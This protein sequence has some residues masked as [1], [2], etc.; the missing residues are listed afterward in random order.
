M[1]IVLSGA[2]TTSAVAQLTRRGEDVVL[3]GMLLVISCR[4]SGQR[5]L[6]RVDSLRP[7]NDFFREGDVWSSVRRLGELE[8]SLLE[9]VA[10][11]YTLAELTLI[12]VLGEKGLGSV[13]RPPAP[14]ARVLMLD[15]AKEA[16]E[17]F[18]AEPGTPGIVW[19]GTLAGYENAP[20]PL[21]VEN[22]TMHMGVFGETGSGKSY[23]VGYL[24]ELLSR[25]PV[26]D[27]E[28]AIPILVIDA[29]GD[30][31]DYH[32]H[33]VEHGELGAF[34]GVMRLVF[35]ISR[36]ANE[37]LTHVLTIGLDEFTAR[38][39]AEFIVGYKYGGL[40]F[41]ELQ[42]SALERTL[43]EVVEETGY[44]YTELLTSRIDLVYAKLNELSTG[45]GAPV[46]HQTAK[47]VRT[48]LEKFENDLVEQYKVVDRKPMLSSSFVD[49]I[50]KEPWLVLIDFSP[51]G[52][53][54]IPLP[55]KQLV[56]GYLTRVLYRQFTEYKVRGD[57]RYLLFVIEE[58]QNYAPNPRN[59]PLG[60]SIARDYLALIAT[61][62]RKF[63]L[64]LCLVSQRPAFIDPVVLSMLNTWFIHRVAPED[65][66]YIA[67]ASGGLPQ[68]LEKRLTSL[69]RGVA[70]V[71]GQMNILGV[72][73]LVEVGRRRVSHEMGRTRV[74]ETLRR[75]YRSG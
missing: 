45:R 31:L 35:S 8:E 23:G 63:G 48:A 44:S 6:A 17:L 32:R 62:G 7:V 2:T 47:A 67:R 39:L 36:A 49:K 43:R 26:G 24:I 15:I 29:N 5:I 75:L 22:I 25:I 30:Y 3:E 11:Q 21:N 60:W 69:P 52:S 38:D 14:G 41:N 73:L 12:G 59:Y 16:K 56:V 13:R 18:G 68:G 66:P 37:P 55:V 1:G 57:E 54:G 64:S 70:V 72:P 42:V 53:P 71:A 61:Q 46:H 20:I 10:R 33:F 9:E 4:R 50:T 34:R 65:V 19:Y 74:V 40:E 27:G 51:E 58:A 28:A